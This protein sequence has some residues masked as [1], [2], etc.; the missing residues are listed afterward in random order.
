MEED[1]VEK[2]VKLD[3]ISALQDHFGTLSQGYVDSLRQSASAG[4][5]EGEKD[6]NAQDIWNLVVQ[7]LTLVEE[8]PDSE[9]SKSESFEKLVAENVR[10]R[11]ELSKTKD[12]AVNSARTLKTLRSSLGSLVSGKES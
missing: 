9:N 7:A 3:P 10:L 5:A 8:I 4:A 2:K 6:Y 11:K 12:E 1:K